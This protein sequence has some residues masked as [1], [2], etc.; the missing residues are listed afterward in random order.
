MKKNITIPA[1]TISFVLCLVI[2]V[3]ADEYDNRRALHN[4]SKA[5]T[6]FDVNM[7]IPEKLVT[8]LKL[9]DATYDQLSIAGAHPEFVIGFR[10]KASR[11]V[12]RG[13]D[14]VFEE[15]IA[16]KKEVY[17]WIKRFKERGIPMEQ[18]LI[19][20]GFQNVD[21][22][23]ILPEIEVVQNGYVSMIGYQ[24]KGYAQVPMD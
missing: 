17:A 23:D 14:Y 6:Y 7:G 4:I 19:A 9:I 12:T 15:D 11:F 21:P 3:F 24:V 22:K 1:L 16:A 13:N 5:K 8:R 20:A 2:V 10:G 18:C